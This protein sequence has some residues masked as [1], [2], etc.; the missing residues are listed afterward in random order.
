MPD[1]AGPDAS[2]P[3]PQLRRAGWRAL[4]GAWD[5]ALDRTARLRDPDAPDFA[6]TIRVPFAPETPASGV[7]E[8]DFFNACWYRRT[9]DATASAGRRVILHFGAVDYAATAWVNGRLVAEHEGGYTPFAADITDALD[10]SGPQTLVVRAH[11]DPHDLA[12][13][14]GKQDWQRDPH[15]I[16]YPRTTGIW[17]TVWLEDVPASHIASLRWTPDLDGWQV[18]LEAE[19]AEPREG[20]RLRVRLS[21]ADRVLADDV[22]ALDGPALRRTVGLHDPGIDNAR[23]DVLWWPWRPTLIDARVELLDAAGDVIDAA[24]SYTALR[25]VAVDD[26]RFLLNGRPYEL[27]LVLDQGYWADTGLTAPDADA[28]RRDV[29]LARAMG[30]N[31]VRKHQKVEDPRYLA[32][33]DRLGLL[34]WEEMPSA[35]RF[36]RTA[37]E[38]MTREWP[39][40]LARDASHPCI[41]AWVPFNESW[42]V[43]DLPRSAEQRHYVE[44]IYHLTKALDPTRPVVGNDGWESVATDIIG[45]HDYDQD[46]ARLAARYAPAELPA[47]LTHGRPARRRITLREH[48]PAPVMLTEFGGVAL[49]KDPKTTWGYSRASSAKEL[50]ERYR[51]LLE[52]V[53]SLDHLAGFCYTQFTDTYQETNGLLYMDR[54]PKLPLDQIR[55]ATAGR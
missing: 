45:I 37:V 53:R 26:E 42:G 44:S 21:I 36:D 50:G 31:G 27:R 20:M 34:V 33:A 52:A 12:K 19:V 11:D 18:A 24:D 29:E 40:V 22:Y 2:Y 46:P 4:D 41:V 55:A 5:F 15:A 32:W 39:R 28:L 43:P 7:G 1:S 13:P 10:D 48:P 25:S 49:A 47:L 6:A 9:F 38:R 51:A 54:T 8:R 14:R 16:W 23:N 3:R 35:Y 30:F 17:Q